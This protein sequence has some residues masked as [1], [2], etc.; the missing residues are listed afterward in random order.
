MS[1][2]AE[3]LFKRSFEIGNTVE[4]AHMAK[5]SLGIQYYNSRCIVHFEHV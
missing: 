1:D 2:D 5:Q 3:H 4:V